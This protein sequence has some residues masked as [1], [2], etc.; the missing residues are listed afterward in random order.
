MDINVGDN[1]QPKAGTCSDE[2]MEP[3][4]VLQIAGDLALVG[5]ESQVQTWIEIANLEVL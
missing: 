1:V 3:G 2:D 5:W 4:A